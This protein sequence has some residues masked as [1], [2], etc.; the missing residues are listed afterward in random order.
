M[1]QIYLWQY[2]PPLTLGSRASRWVNR[3]SNQENRYTAVHA[4]Q[5]FEKRAMAMLVF[6]KNYGSKSGRLH[7]EISCTSWAKRPDRT[8]AEVCNTIDLIIV[9]RRRGVIPETGW[10]EIIS[11][12]YL[13]C[14]NLRFD[15]HSGL[16]L[17]HGLYLGTHLHIPISHNHRRKRTLLP[18]VSNRCGL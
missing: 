18:R 2:F 13:G 5:G 6:N 9:P 3:S 11:D 10:N 4:S 17:I 15:T 16:L 12:E 8:H 1:I 7:N 14:L